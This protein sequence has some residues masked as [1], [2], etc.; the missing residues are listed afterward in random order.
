MQ[1]KARTTLEYARPG[2]FF[3]LPGWCKWMPV[4]LLV[5]TLVIPMGARLLDFARTGNSYQADL[6]FPVG[7]LGMAIFAASIVSLFNLLFAAK[8]AG[9]ANPLRKP[10][11]AV[12]GIAVLSLLLMPLLVYMQRH[13]DFLVVRMQRRN[14]LALDHF[15]KVIAGCQSYVAAHTD[16]EGGHFPPHLAALVAGGYLTPEDLIDPSSWTRPAVVRAGLVESD[17]PKIAAEI[18]AHCDYVYLGADL[19][20]DKALRTYGFIGGGVFMPSSQMAVGYS[21]TSHLGEGTLLWIWGERG[22]DV[23]FYDGSDFSDVWAKSNQS[24]EQI[25]LPALTFGG[26]PPT[27]ATRPYAMAAPRPKAQQ[28]A[29]D[30]ITLRHGKAIRWAIMNYTMDHENYFPPHLAALIAGHYIVPDDLLVP[31]LRTAKLPLDV[32][33]LSEADWPKIAADVEAH[34]DFIYVGG[35]FP[36]RSSKL[37]TWPDPQAY[38][39]SPPFI[40][41]YVPELFS[42]ETDFVF[43]IPDNLYE[44]D[45][46]TTNSEG[47]H[48]CF[49]ENNGWRGGIGVGLPPIRPGERPTLKI[50]SPA[51]RGL[52]KGAD[53]AAVNRQ[54]SIRNML[55][56]MT[57]IKYNRFRVYGSPLRDEGKLISMAEARLISPCHL[58]DPDLNTPMLDPDAPAFA[59]AERQAYFDAHCDYC[60]CDLPLSP[61]AG[62]RGDGV[63]VVLYS[64]NTYNHTGRLCELSSGAVRVFTWAQL[65]S[66]L[67]EE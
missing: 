31:P 29:D 12:Y 17:W 62:V 26:P 22:G 24:R 54:V 20:Q 48:Q 2:A 59:G 37:T 13:S 60:E 28:E 65:P 38:G 7:L 52:P 47:W 41:F 42:G 51:V 18:D 40:L 19:V 36:K 63:R 23:R 34:S 8:A 9:T 10:M 58:H 33:G 66:E 64:K 16:A 57:T 6:P 56:I 39:G 25:F 15:R 50:P 3:R 21:K 53:A 46:L 61:G 5:A 11:R 32:S 4:V 44:K 30:A 45:R 35:D 1:D 27:P 43:R 67:R 49:V 14:E 55:V